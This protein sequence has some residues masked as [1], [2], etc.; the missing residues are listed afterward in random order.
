MQMMLKMTIKELKV[1]LN[2]PV[3][4]SLAICFLSGNAMAQQQD[5]VSVSTESTQDHMMSGFDPMKYS[6]LE[7]TD[8][9]DSQFS[10]HVESYSFSEM[11]WQS[12]VAG[13]GHQSSESTAPF[14]TSQQAVIYFI[15]GAQLQPSISQNNDGMPRFDFKDLS[16]LKDGFMIQRNWNGV[17]LHYR[18]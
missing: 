4:F 3:L 10:S 2:K 14:L 6:G 7:N 8:L 5:F 1:F 18:F 13:V 15:L 11:Q 9:L 17:E 12:E 16:Q